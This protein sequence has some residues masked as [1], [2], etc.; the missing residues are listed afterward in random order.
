MNRGFSRRMCELQVPVQ[1]TAG[2][3]TTAT[4]IR[5][6]LLHIITAPEVYRKLRLEIDNAIGKGQV[7]TPIKFSEAKELPYVS[8]RLPFSLQSLIDYVANHQIGCRL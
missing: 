7:S 4:A 8:V 2:T 3:E 1:L 5:S 6:T